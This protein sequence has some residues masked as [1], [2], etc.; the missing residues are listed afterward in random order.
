MNFAIGFVL[1]FLVAAGLM[2]AVLSYVVRDLTK[3]YEEKIKRLER[4]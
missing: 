1:G 3:F 4:K 2:F